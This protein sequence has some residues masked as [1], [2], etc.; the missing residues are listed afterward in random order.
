[1][2]DG[3]RVVGADEGDGSGGVR[4]RGIPRPSPVGFLTL[5]ERQGEPGSLL[6]VG[7]HMKKPLSSIFVVQSESHYS[8]L[9]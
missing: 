1:M 7:R 8:C 2:F 6:T 9:W 4:L 5:F 3:E